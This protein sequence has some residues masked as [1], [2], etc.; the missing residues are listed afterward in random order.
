MS[1]VQRF[2]S[3]THSLSLSLQRSKRD[4]TNF[5]ED[6]TK[7]NPEL[8]PMGNDVVQS[9]NQTEFQDFTF[10]NSEFPG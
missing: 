8:T 5:D 1:F 2:Y 9:L 7:E 3:L 6:F 10:T 4:A